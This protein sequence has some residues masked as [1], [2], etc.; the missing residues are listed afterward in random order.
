MKTVKVLGLVV[1]V[2]ILIGIGLSM[3][4]YGGRLLFWAFTTY[5]KP[6][7]E[8]DPQDA[9]AAPDYGLPINWA[10][11][12]AKKDPADLVPEGI[13][14]RPQGEHPVDVFFIHPTGF[15]TSGS[16]TSPMNLASGTEQNTAYMMANQASA[17]NGCCNIYAPRYREA[18]IFSYFAGSPADRDEVLGFAYQDV[19]RAFEHYLQHE[20]QG[21]PFII[22]GHSQG[23]HHARRLLKEA[24]DAS[25]LHQRMV[26]A[27]LIGSIIIPVSPSWF[28][29]LN[30]IT[31][32]EN[33]EDIHC[34]V[35][36]DT[37]P[38][39][40]PALERPEESLCTN[41]LSWQVDEELANEDLNEGA[42][43]PTGTLNAAIGKHADTPAQQVF[44]SLGKPINGLTWA[45][46]KNG[47]LYVKN[48]LA[49][50]FEVDD[51]GTYHVLDYALFYMN[52][53][54]NAKRRSQ[55]YLTGSAS[56]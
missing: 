17:F 18:N 20:N 46:C 54:N 6:A 27:Y 40:A 36:W 24:V 48:E 7:G 42:V 15:L 29:S 49:T 23:S 35:H 2:V 37:M 51:M 21:R 28:A 22:A 1:I 10:A 44:E 38:S 26:A 25:D 56:P 53:H 9:V 39:G 11:L 43:V 50:G 41:P 45:Q 30:H 5:N 52:I 31:P 47:T 34:V 16:W 33:A 12:P 13:A 32:C 3:T 4:G 55:R 8:F 14:V 19:K